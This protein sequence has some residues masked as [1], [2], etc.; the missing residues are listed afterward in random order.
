MTTVYVH[1][2]NQSQTV[3]CSDGSQGVMRISNIDVAPHYSF[4]FY[5]HAHMGFWLNQDQFHDGQSLVVKGVLENEQFK[6]QF[7]D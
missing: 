7:V 3:A 4:K 6:I 2:N 1:N 5:S